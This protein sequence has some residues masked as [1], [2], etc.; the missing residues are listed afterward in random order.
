[1]TTDEAQRQRERWRYLGL[2]V[3]GLALLVTLGIQLI[4]LVPTTYTATSAIA[5]RP[6]TAD[7]APEAVEMQAHEYSVALGADE[8]AAEV[9]TAVDGSE[10]ADLS[11][12]ATLDTGT[13]TV[14]IATTSTDRDTAINVA[15]G[16]AD[17]AVELG[18]GDPT[19]QVVVVVRAGVEGVDSAPPRNLYIAALLALA[20]LLLAGGLYQIR[21]RL[22]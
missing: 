9:L 13:S 16:L 21:E 10:E 11:V 7:L 8:T 3:G 14:R 5:L 4:L 20:G 6:V 22:S 2:L 19:A 18:G 12:T 1:M 17:R 15:N